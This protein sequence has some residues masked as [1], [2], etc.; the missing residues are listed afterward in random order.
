MLHTAFVSVITDHSADFGTIGRAALSMT[1]QARGIE[2]SEQ[3]RVQVMGGML[4]LPPHPEVPAAL[5]RLK[6]AGL[7]LAALTNSTKEA[8]DA[9]LSYAGLYSSFERVLSVEYAG[10]LK[11]H[12]SVYQ[13]A[14]E[15]LGVEPRGMRLVAAHNWDITG[16]MRVGCAG[17]FIARPGMI[18]G[19]LDEHPDISGP[20]LRV[21]ADRIIE[22][23]LGGILE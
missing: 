20:D 5:G 7:H 14:A 10:R 15:H 13:M 2:L 21:V 18:L 11:P 16:A 6:D 12:P 4:S 19:P 1:A 3:D 8:A 22:V 23:E 17:A 9:Q